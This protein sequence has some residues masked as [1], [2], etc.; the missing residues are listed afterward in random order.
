MLLQAAAVIAG[1]DPGLIKR[2]P[3]TS[4]LKNEI[5][6]LEHHREIG[7]IQAWRTAGARLVE[8]NIDSAELAETAVTMVMDA[9][10][11][12]T[13]AVGFVATRWLRQDPPGFLP[14]L[15][16]AAHDAGIPVIA[17]VA[18]MLPPFENLRRYTDEGIDLVSF[19]G[20]KAIRAPQSSGILAGTKELIEAAT[21]NAAPNSAVGRPAKVCKEEIVGLM[22][23][24][25]LYA[26]RDH[27]ADQRRWRAQGEVIAAALKDVSGVRVEV[28]QDDHS[29]PVPEAAIFFSEGYRGPPRENI[30]GL[31]LEE[32][33][34]IVLGAAT[35]RGEDLYV[36]PHNM[37]EG[38]D[39]VVGAR[40]RAMLSGD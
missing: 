33:P 37:A 12:R 3:D 34:R 40:L 32:E 11:P 17:D 24:L 15:T 35:V 38:E 1:T 27:A 36:N 25:K 4:G 29:R 19:S 30:A 5:I 8:V 13:A 31:L 28:L 23:A 6:I 18:A 20:G 7:Y 39:Q 9:V 14:A 10:G 22:T 2:L 16:R 26:G 21:M